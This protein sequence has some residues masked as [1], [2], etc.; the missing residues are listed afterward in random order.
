MAKWPKVRSQI[1][2]P[3]AG[4]VDD[5]WVVATVWA[6][7]AF[8][9][10]IHQPDVPEFRRHAGDPDD[11]NHADGGSLDEMV[12]GAR[13]V[14]PGVRV[15]RYDGAWTGLRDRVKTGRPASLAVRASHLPSSMRFG[16]TGAHQ[17][18]VGWDAD[19]TTF[20][21][22]NPLAPEGSKPKAI[23]A[24][25]LRDAA[26]AMPFGGRV[27]ATIFPK[28]TGGDMAIFEISGPDSGP[29][30]VTVKARH[31]RR[32]PGRHDEGRDDRRRVDAV[33]GRGRVGGREAGVAPR[34]GGEPTDAP[35]LRREVGHPT[36]L[37]RCCHSVRARLRRPRPARHSP[38]P[39]SCPARDPGT[40]PARR[41]GTRRRSRRGR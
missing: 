37:S 25:V 27:Q 13:G 12:R 21:V 14:W 15:E 8:R 16:F 38:G 31:D 3:G 18:G 39:G 6:A 24:A 33:R 41:R 7:T 10:D 17:I 32:R 35:W 11:P 40:P 29:Y 28:R 9:E 5:C 34:T 36:R 26:K 30:P 23:D 19:R 2:F 22:A 1:G 20:V 4:N